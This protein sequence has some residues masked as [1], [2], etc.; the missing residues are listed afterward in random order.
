MSQAQM[1][2]LLN[3]NIYTVNRVFDQRA[4]YLVKQVLSSS[5]NPM[6]VKAYHDVKE[7]GD[8]RGWAHLHGV[9][10]RKPDTTEA[11]FRKLHSGEQVSEKEKQDLAALAETIVCV[12][13]LPDRIS[14]KFPDLAG[15][16]ASTIAGLAAKYQCHGCTE[17]CERPQ[18]VG[19]WYRFPREPSGLTLIAA[20]PPKRMPKGVSSM[21][22]GQASAV[23]EAVKAKII[24][25]NTHELQR[26]STQRLVT[27]AIGPAE[28]LEDGSGVRWNRGFFP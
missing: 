1:A 14:S 16:R 25:M 15:E 5:V 8:V 11:I 26:I 24:R 13:L 18:I 19:C 12:R 7:F 17:K 23:K 20:P 6:Q 9:A 2:E 22:L 3:R 28:M 4:R 27:Q 10:W 21:L